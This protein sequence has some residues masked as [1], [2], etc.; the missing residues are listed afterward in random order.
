[1]TSEEVDD[2]TTERDDKEENFM[3]EEDRPSL[4]H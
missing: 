4:A 1:M 2:S 3:T